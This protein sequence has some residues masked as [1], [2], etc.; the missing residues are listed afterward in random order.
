MNYSKRT[1]WTRVPLSTRTISFS[2]VHHFWSRWITKLVFI[3]IINVGNTK[4][5]I[6]EHHYKVCIAPGW[7][8]RE[9]IALFGRTF[10]FH[11]AWKSAPKLH[12]K[13]LPKFLM[14]GNRYF[15]RFPDHH[16]LYWTGYSYY[17]LLS[18]NIEGTFNCYVTL[19]FVF[20]HPFSPICNDL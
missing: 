18:S 13:H 2:S 7:D 19:N 6:E 9:K 16:R 5:T 1:A 3:T 17:S 4:M 15:Q 8:T 12:S 11:A 20:L 10:I 14:C